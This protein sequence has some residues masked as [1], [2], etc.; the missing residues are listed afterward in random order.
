MIRT[1]VI[2]DEPNA[3]QVVKNI[4]E[5]YCKSTK[6]VGEAASASEGGKVINEVKPDLVFLDNRMPD[7]TG[8]N[9][10]KKVRVEIAVTADFLETTINTIVDAAKTGTIG[11]GKIFVTN[12]EECIRIRTGEKGDD[13]IG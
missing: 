12:L 13:A 8:F 11:D 3:R 7:G 5:Q 9:L 2:D 4:L 1:V 6:L 10:L